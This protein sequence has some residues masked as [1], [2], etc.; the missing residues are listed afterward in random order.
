MAMALTVGQFLASHHVDYSLMRHRHTDTSFSSA[1]S[2]HVPTAQVAKAVMLKDQN[3]EF[4]MAVVPSNRRVMI[5]KI[6]RMMGKQYF[7][8]G[9]HE[10]S[11]IFQDCEPGAVPSLGPAYQVDMLVDDLLLEQDELYIESGDHENLIHLD[12]K[13]FHRA[14]QGV[15]HQNISGYRMLFSQAHDGRHWEWE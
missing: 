6:S 15:P 11:T 7:L 3:N 14:I 1:I 12:K 9:E 8:I 4:L 13:Q 5:D 10:L 2:A